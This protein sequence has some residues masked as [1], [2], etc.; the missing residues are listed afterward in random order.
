[1]SIFWRKQKHEAA[2]PAGLISV[3][4]DDSSDYGSRDD[5]AMDLSAFDQI[6][7]E[8]ALLQMASDI[9]TDEQLQDT[10]GESLGEIWVR[11]GSIPSE[12]FDLLTPTAKRSAA[13]IFDALSANPTDNRS[14]NSL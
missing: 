10:C 7:V 14:T 2:Q 6:E 1:M 5:A 4:L 3:L 9:K 11:K 8:N 13:T 12:K